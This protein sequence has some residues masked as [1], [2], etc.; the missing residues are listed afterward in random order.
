MLSLSSLAGL[1]ANVCYPFNPTMNC[2]AI[3]CL[4]VR[5]SGSLAGLSSRLLSGDFILRMRSGELLFFIIGIRSSENTE[6]TSMD[7]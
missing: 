6:Y 7:T 3:F 4:P 2:G 5:R 1:F